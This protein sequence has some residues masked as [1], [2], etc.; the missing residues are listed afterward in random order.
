MSESM[1]CQTCM[2][3][4]LMCCGNME[5]EDHGIYGTRTVCCGRPEPCN[6]EKGDEIAAK[7]EA[8]TASGAR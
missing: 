4:G 8:P 7:R 6:C 5:V 3:T 1:I 2:N